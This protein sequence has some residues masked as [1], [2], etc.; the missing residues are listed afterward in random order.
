MSHYWQVLWMLC[1][2]YWRKRVA[3]RAL[4]RNAV[5]ARALPVVLW[6][7]FELLSALHFQSWGVLHQHQRGL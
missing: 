4:Q 1:L 3:G 6:E 7:V 2:L 5:A